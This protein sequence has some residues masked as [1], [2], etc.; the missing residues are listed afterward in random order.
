MKSQTAKVLHKVAG[1]PMLGHVIAGL[2]AAGVSRSRARCSCSRV[3][4]SCSGGVFS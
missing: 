4:M 1:L 3:V 2:K